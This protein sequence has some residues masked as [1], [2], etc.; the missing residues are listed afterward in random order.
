V[1]PA[2]L[3]LEDAALAH[4]SA[5]THVHPVQEDRPG[6]VAP[7][8]L[9]LLPQPAVVDGDGSLVPDP[10]TGGYDRP[11]AIDPA[12][13]VDPDV[14]ARYV[15]DVHLV[16]TSRV[17]GFGMSIPFLIICKLYPG[18]GVEHPYRVSSVKTDGPVKIVEPFEPWIVW[19]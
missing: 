6:E 10:G 12:P 15:V 5:E 9:H 3:L 16:T 7:F 14:R 2:C 4:L 8:K 1:R 11:L 18:I 19:E 13:R 17:S